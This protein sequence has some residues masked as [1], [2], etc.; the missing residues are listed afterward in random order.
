MKLL[1]ALSSFAALTVFAADEPPKLALTS[2]HYTGNGNGRTAELCG[3]VSGKRNANL[4]VNVTVDP[5]NDSG[6]YVTWPGADGRF[7]VIVNS[8]AGRVEAGLWDGASA[9]DQTNVLEAQAR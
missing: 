1:I 3:R 7:C 4:R 8:L 9:L 2:F 6:A 5:G